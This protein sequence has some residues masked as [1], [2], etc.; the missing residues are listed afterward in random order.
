[1]ASFKRIYSVVERSSKDSTSNEGTSFMRECKEK[2]LC[3][4]IFELRR[5]D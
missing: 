5:K 1:M 3:I 4:G 2:V